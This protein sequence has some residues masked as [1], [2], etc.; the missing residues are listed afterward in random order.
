M[1]MV[2][3]CYFVEIDDEHEDDGYWTFTAKDYVTKAV[4]ARL[5]R[6]LPAPDEDPGWEQSCYEELKDFV[7]E[8]CGYAYDAEVDS[9]GFDVRI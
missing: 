4:V 1:F 6:T 8:F 9:S 7:A 2:G 5:K 3:D